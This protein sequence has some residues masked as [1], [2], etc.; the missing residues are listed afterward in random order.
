MSAPWIMH[1]QTHIPKGVA[2]H[3][4]PAFISGDLIGEVD[5]GYVIPAGKVLHLK[6][7][8]IEP[9]WSG[10]VIIY[11][12]TGTTNETWDQSK[13]L[14][15]YSSGGQL[16]DPVTTIAT[17]KYG[18]GSPVG[19]ALNTPPDTPP[20]LETLV[21]ELDYWIKAGE[22]VNVRLSNGWCPAGDW[23]YGWELTGELLDA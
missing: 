14:G 17:A 4:P 9:L 18:D 23:I 19:W 22:Q 8:K 6:R 15:T 20:L 21:K 1:A 2:I 16:F 11:T 13:S 3:N 10:A 7:V 5:T 12:G